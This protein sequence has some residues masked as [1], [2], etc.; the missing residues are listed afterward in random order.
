MKSATKR[1]RGLPAKSL[2]LQRRISLQKRVE[3]LR[4]N[5]LFEN[6]DDATFKRIRK[7]LVERHYRAG[8]LIR[9]EDDPSKCL[10]L[11]VTGRVRIV[12]TDKSNQE[13]LLALL[14]ERDFFGELELIDGRESNSHVIAAEDC[15]LYELPK[16]TFDQL[17]SGNHPFAVRLLQVLSVRL[18]ALNHHHAQQLEHFAEHSRAELEKLRR[19]INATEVVNSTLNIDELL[20]LIIDTALGI[21]D[22]EAGTLYLIDPE[23]QEL[24][25]KVLRGSTYVEIHMPLGKGIAGYVAATRE[26]INIPNAYLDPRFN[27]EI[28]AMTGYHTTSILCT[29]IINKNGQIVGVLQLLNKRDGGFGEDDESFVNALSIHSALALDNAKAYELERQRLVIEKELHAARNVQMSLLPQSPPM[30]E[31][32]DIAGRTITARLVGGDYF[33]FIPVDDQRTIICL[34]DVSGKG[35]PAALLMANLQAILRSELML[36]TSPRRTM[37]RTNKLLC[38]STASDKFVTLFYGL[39]D[40]LSHTFRYTNAGH[41]WPILLRK[42]IEPARLSKSGLVLGIQEETAYEE[43]TVV[44]QLGDTLVIYSDGVNEAMNPNNEQF[45]QQKLESFLRSHTHLRAAEM[46]DQLVAALKHHAGDAPQADD[47]TVIV[48]KRIQ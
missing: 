7:V 20:P 3:R 46:I 4:H 30:I 22:A 19:L 17:L 36:K 42:G 45:G 33:D 12:R 11:I 18:R 48:V 40:N 5:T 31:G 8:E 41:E 9:K 39:L 32:Y 26:T 1:K 16:L 2:G 37:R 27:P 10:F 28:D 24:W 14:H 43:N 6:I 15:I 35:L 25:S 13:V 38:Q 23:K 21:V 29:P 34:G 44:L 47:I